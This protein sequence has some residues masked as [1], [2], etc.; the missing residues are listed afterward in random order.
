MT[1]HTGVLEIDSEDDILRARQQ[2]REVAEA[3]GFRV[4]DVTR[5]VTAVSELSRN[6]YLYAGHGEMQWRPLESNGKSGLEFTFIDT[7][8]GIADVEG[9]L[10]G[11]YSTSDG[12]G[13][14]L[15]GTK[16]LVDEIDIETESGV[17]TTVTIIKWRA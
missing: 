11:E 15:V 14:G 4:T 7:G 1:E 16:Q 10:A 17:G 5:I 8:P 2:A 13:R 3:I 6:V 12:M 9:A